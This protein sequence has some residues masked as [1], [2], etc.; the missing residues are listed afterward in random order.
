M[1]KK[2]T[3]EDLTEFVRSDFNLLGY[4]TYA[5]VCLYGGGSRRCDMFA[6]KDNESIVFEAKLS[7]NLKVIEQAYLWKQNANKVFVLIPKTHKQ[8]KSRI[9]ARKICESLGIGVMEV[10]IIT[11]K[12]TITVQPQI[13]NKPKLPKLYEEQK[14]TKASNDKNEF[15]TPFKLTVN[16]LNDYMKNKKKDL[17][18]NVV[19]NIDHHYSNDKSAVN[20]IKKL[21]QKNVIKNFYIKKENN[22]I[23]I[24]NLKY[25]IN[26]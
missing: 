9:F 23:V 13:N 15:V 5:E 7:F 24:V 16:K 2:I 22:K 18:N 12:Y 14:L 21:I 25:L 26:E 17:L 11:G 8:I 10:N 6:V 20:A 19:K 4:T 3:E 1:N